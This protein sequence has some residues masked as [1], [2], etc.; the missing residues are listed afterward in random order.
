MRYLAGINLD[1]FTLGQGGEQSSKEK[2]SKNNEKILK[3]VKENVGLD[4]TS[5]EDI[6]VLEEDQLINVKA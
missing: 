5:I 3:N 6:K 1:S 4:G 2:N